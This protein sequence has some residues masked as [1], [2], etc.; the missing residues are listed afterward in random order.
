MRLFRIKPDCLELLAPFGRRIA[1]PFDANAAGQAALKGGLDKVGCEEGERD[2]YVDLPDAALLPEADFLDGGYSTGDDVVEPLAAFG[3]NAHEAC[4]A[5]ELLRLD[6]PPRRI[7]R[8]Q[9]PARSFVGGFCLGIVM[10]P[11]IRSRS[12]MRYC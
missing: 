6:F 10:A 7:M 2:R 5:L 11:Q 8:Q 12:R 3:D 1:E 9:D 4:P